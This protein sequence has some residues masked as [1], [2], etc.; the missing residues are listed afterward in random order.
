[1]RPDS[2][3]NDGGSKSLRSRLAIKRG[4]ETKRW[5]G[6]VAGRFRRS[7]YLFRRDNELLI[8]RPISWEERRERKKEKKK[9]RRREKI[10]YRLPFPRG[11]KHDSNRKE[12]LV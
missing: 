2:H 9:K 12:I 7:A 6:P 1:M 10:E 3:E 11:R 5:G 4:G 8:F